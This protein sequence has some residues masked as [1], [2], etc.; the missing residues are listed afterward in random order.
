MSE[1]ETLRGDADWLL[2]QLDAA[3]AEIES[4]K[5]DIA[6]LTDAANRQASRDSA[7]PSDE[8]IW[9]QAYFAARAQH[10]WAR[11]PQDTADWVLAEYR[12]RWPR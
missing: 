11:T 7:R 4:L 10:T 2:A 12:K 8:D 5:A 6:R 3:R 1:L 9:R